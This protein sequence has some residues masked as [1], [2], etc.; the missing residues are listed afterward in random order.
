MHWGG[1]AGTYVLAVWVLANVAASG[2]TA[3]LRVIAPLGTD[4]PA[5]F[6]LHA[7]ATLGSNVTY[8]HLPRSWR[9]AGKA[10]KDTAASWDPR[11]TM[12][13]ACTQSAKDARVLAAAL[14]GKDDPSG[15]FVERIGNV[16]GAGEVRDTHIPHR[17]VF[18][19][20]G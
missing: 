3:C 4:I 9:G 18:R 11:F 16:A 8:T 6:A 12:M 17:G 14:P 7:G 10:G 19:V 15:V 5:Y 20:H 1:Y 13:M 2:D